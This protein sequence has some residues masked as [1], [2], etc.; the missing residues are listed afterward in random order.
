MSDKRIIRSAYLVGGN[1]KAWRVKRL[2]NTG[3]QSRSWR[4]K[5]LNNTRKQSEL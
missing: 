5:R 4:V 1:I 2:N 3:K